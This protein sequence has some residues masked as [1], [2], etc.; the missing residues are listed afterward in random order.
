MH[1]LHLRIAASD[2]NYATA[3]KSIIAFEDVGV[4]DIL[5]QKLANERYYF[6]RANTTGSD[7]T[8]YV[9]GN[10]VSINNACNL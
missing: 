6:T 8:V 9:S 4:L 7:K 5:L 1:N 3:Q 2:A 10:A